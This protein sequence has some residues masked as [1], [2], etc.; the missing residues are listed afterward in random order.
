MVCLNEH[1]S[2]NKNKLKNNLIKELNNS[3]R[4]EFQIEIEKNKLLFEKIYKHN[5]NKI[6]ELFLSNHFLYVNMDNNLCSHMFKK[7]NKEGYFCQ[8]KITKNGDKDNYVCT[9]HN[10]NHNPMKKKKKKIIKDNIINIPT[11]S[12]DKFI[13]L[14]KPYGKIYKNKNK[15]KNK[16]IK[17]NVYGEINFNNIIKRLSQEISL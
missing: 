15:M 14:K 7:G 1:L 3:I 12:H 16:K 9:K 10:K 4:L 8:K 17:I 11:K 5:E 13:L 6:K 2:F